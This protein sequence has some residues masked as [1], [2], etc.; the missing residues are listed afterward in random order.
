MAQFK[1]SAWFSLHWVWSPGFSRLNATTLMVPNACAKALY[2][3]K[4]GLQTPL[5]FQ[6]FDRL[7]GGASLVCSRAPLTEL[8]LAYHRWNDGTGLQ[9][10]D[11]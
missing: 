10:T 6:P 7:T 1:N 8:F 2:R 11:L 3:L 4:P 5:H 9:I